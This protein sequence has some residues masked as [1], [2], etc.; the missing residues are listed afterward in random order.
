MN[1]LF[2]IIV[3]VY[4]VQSFLKICIDSILK[5]S[6]SDFELILIDDGSSDNSGNICDEYAKKD[7]RIKVV[8]KE[9]GGSSSARNRGLSIAK[10]QWIVFIDSDDWVD[11]SLLQ[12]YIPYIYDYDIIFQGMIVE[13]SDFKDSSY[14][15]LEDHKFIG[16]QVSEGIL[17]LERKNMIGW[18]CNKA[19]KRELIENN[20]IR[21]QEDISIQEDHIFTLEYCMSIS[22]LLCLSTAYYHYRILD[23][24]LIRRY[25]PYDLLLRKTEL[26]YKYRLLI[27]KRFHSKELELFSKQSYYMSRVDNIQYAYIGNKKLNR[28]ERIFL[29]KNNLVYFDKLNFR[30]FSI[31]WIIGRISFVRSLF[32]IDVLISGLVF[33]KKILRCYSL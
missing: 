23:N 18:M 3:P 12:S 19:F 30:P 1:P 25:K 7:S 6:C 10:G 26:L 8:H 9:N 2:S 32:L 11:D 20:R 21:F 24:S 33:F 14:Q 29:L 28:K 16:E 15:I 5:Q 27:S 4:N 22:S 13:R 31:N 17:Y